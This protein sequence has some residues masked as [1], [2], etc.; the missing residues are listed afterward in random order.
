M[1]KYEVLICNNGSYSKILLKADSYTWGGT[2][3]NPRTTFSI[4]GETVG[5][6][7][8]NYVVSIVILS[9]ETGRT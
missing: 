4:G 9:K 2:A 8:P 3:V 6:F 5:E 1:N 7:D